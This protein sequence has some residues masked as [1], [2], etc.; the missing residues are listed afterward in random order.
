MRASVSPRRRATPPLL[1]FPFDR[2]CPV[3]IAFYRSMNLATLLDACELSS[4]TTH[5]TA[6]CVEAARFMGAFISAALMGES[7]EAL[8]APGRFSNIFLP[9][10]C[11][12]SLPLEGGGAAHGGTASLGPPRVPEMQGIVAA[13]YLRKDP[14]VIN[15]SGNAFNTLEAA[16][17]AFSRTSTWADGCFAAVNLGRDRCVFGTFIPP[18]VTIACGCWLVVSCLVRVFVACETNGCCQTTP[19]GAPP[20]AHTSCLGLGCAGGGSLM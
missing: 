5:S 11:G 20:T 10:A 15:G 3:P 17:W 7:K 12:N 2:I 14:P 9:S 8:L 19:R 18:V 6:T 16:L 13:D 1:L 4:R